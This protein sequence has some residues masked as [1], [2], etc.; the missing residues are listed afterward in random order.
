MADGS[1]QLYVDPG[2][3]MPKL[4]GWLSWLFKQQELGRYNPEAYQGSFWQADSSPDF[5]SIIGS[6][7]VTAQHAACGLPCWADLGMG[8]YQQRL[9]HGVVLQAHVHVAR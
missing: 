4:R 6:D 3:F 9:A 1:T 7:K 5:I 2:G 8:Q